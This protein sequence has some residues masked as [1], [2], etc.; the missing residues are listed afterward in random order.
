MENTSSKICDEFILIN[1]PEFKL[2]FIF[3]EKKLKKLKIII[4]KKVLNIIPSNS[5]FC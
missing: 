5:V 1:T 2:D 4:L 3:R